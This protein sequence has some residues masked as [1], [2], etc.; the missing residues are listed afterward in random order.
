MCSYSGLTDVSKSYFLQESD[1][2]RY[3][4]YFGDGILG[5]KPV[6]GNIVILEYV[7][8]NKTEGLMQVLLLYQVI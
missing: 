4:V 2:E 7:V 1:D 3:E 6:D 8:T 5:K